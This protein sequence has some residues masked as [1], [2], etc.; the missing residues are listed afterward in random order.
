MRL[1]VYLSE[2]KSVA[3]LDL[4]GSNQFLSYLQ[5]FK[6]SALPPSFSLKLYA[7]LLE[8]PLFYVVL[9]KGSCISLLKLP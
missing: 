3:I 1:K 6:G 5:S 8:E 7:S 4:I 9:S 2:V